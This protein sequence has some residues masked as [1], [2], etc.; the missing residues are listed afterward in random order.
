MESAQE[1]LRN[2]R[3]DSC[4][5]RSGWFVAGTE[6]KLRNIVTDVINEHISDERLKEIGVDAEERGED[7]HM[8]EMEED[9]PSG[10]QTE[11]DSDI[12]EQ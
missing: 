7:E 5:E 1:L 6:E 2:S 11:T 4:S 3:S 10:M 9:V 12:D 8:E